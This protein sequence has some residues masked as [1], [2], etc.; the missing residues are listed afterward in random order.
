[1][2]RFLSGLVARSLTPA[3]SGPPPAGDR[4]AGQG[5]ER[6]A[7]PAPASG[8]RAR[9]PALFDP[10]D[11]AMG[12]P[13]RPIAEAP[14]PGPRPMRDD[15]PTESIEQALSR[16]SV[17]EPRRRVSR[18]A[19]VAELRGAGRFPDGDAIPESHAATDVRATRHHD[20]SRPAL[21]PHPALAS[22]P[23]APPADAPDPVASRPEAPVS[24]P[25]GRD[26]AGLPRRPAGSDVPPALSNS[27]SARAPR[28]EIGNATGDRRTGRPPDEPVTPRIEPRSAESRPHLHP[29]SPARAD[30][31]PSGTIVRVSIGRIEVRTAPPPPAPQRSPSRSGPAMSLDDYLRRR[32]RD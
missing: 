11:D 29:E 18:S 4:S 9:L 25:P 28:P 2:S 10:T 3:Y 14:D 30:D 16:P 21:D 31:R 6:S 13:L 32:E 22:G 23:Y 17:A 19:I 27:I 20:A 24:S 7:R 8:V 15:A 1:M 5:D 12:A 26:L